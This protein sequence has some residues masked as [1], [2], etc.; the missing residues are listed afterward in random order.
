MSGEPADFTLGA[1]VR[2]VTHS[3]FGLDLR[4]LALLRI[5]LGLILLTDLILRS[6]DLVAHYTD[7]GV[8]PR[9]VLLETLYV[10]GWYS[11]H[12][13][14]GV[15]PFQAA[16]FLMAAAAAVA[17]VIGYRTTL[18]T[19]LS[20]FFLISLQARNPLLL[21][22]GDDLLRLVLF[23]S[24]FLPWGATWSWD[25]GRRANSAVV[26]SAASVGYVGQLCLLYVF[27]AT[28]KTGLQWMDGSAVYY[29]LSLDMFTRPL[30][31]QL[32]NYPE[33]L[34]ILT[35][36]VR[37]LQYAI[38]ALLL[39]PVANSLTRSLALVGML[40]M[41]AGIALCMDIGLFSYISACAGLGLIPSS[42]WE[43]A[44]H[45]RTPSPPDGEKPGS[46]GV[47]PAPLN[48]GLGLLLLYVIMWNLGHLPSK[49]WW[50][51]Q[52]FRLDQHWRMFAPSPLAD[53][54]WFVVEG[55]LQN[56]RIVD[57]LHGRKHVD[58]DKPESV[59]R[60]YRNQRWRRYLTAL[61][62][63]GN[64]YHRTSYARYLQRGWDDRHRGTWRLK[65]VRI[66]FVL[67]RTLP[68]GSE[69][70][71]P[72]LLLSYNCDR[73]AERDGFEELFGR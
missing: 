61:Y 55:E 53:D 27:A 40:G 11:L 18:A 60:S 13:G 49:V 26:V 30:G 58:F 3:V 28:S 48:L 69:P 51:G 73:K 1:R 54:G 4:S 10:P 6:R 45:F 19:A 7:Q 31:T 50:V 43:R 15:W 22:S 34:E 2:R 66:F 44:I 52:L 35:Y 46:K 21:N 16:L 63:S 62:E 72:L 33:F 29:T 68:Q 23:W 59:L 71:K 39:C 25:E 36:A 12:L 14:S 24:I 47:L 5:S 57:L 64:R 37:G 42:W 65:Q 17:V 38:P 8:L 32:L 41:H 20:W 56:G 67:E 70:P 9:S